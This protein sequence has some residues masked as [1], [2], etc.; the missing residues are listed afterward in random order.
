M[1]ESIA[2]VVRFGSLIDRSN[3]SMILGKIVEGRVVIPVSF[4]LAHATDLAIDFVVDTGFNGY[5]TLPVPAVAAL[6]LPLDSS[7]DYS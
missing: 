6:K 1:L 4:C 7:L 5:L 3:R 2:A